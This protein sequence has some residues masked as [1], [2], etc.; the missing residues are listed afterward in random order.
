MVDNPY[1]ID[2]N[3][4]PYCGTS[5]F[6]MSAIDFTNG[7]PFYLKFKVNMGGYE[8]YVTQLVR[9]RVESMEFSS[10][11]VVCT[12]AKT[13]FSIGLYILFIL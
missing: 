1:Q 12:A 11:S 13:A 4:C 2:L 8:C 10:D 3:Q 9:P 7:E 6:D 5:Y